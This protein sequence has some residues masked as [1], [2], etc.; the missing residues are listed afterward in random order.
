MYRKNEPCVPADKWVAQDRQ[1]EVKLSK[2]GKAALKRFEDTFQKKFGADSLKRKGSKYEVISTGSLTLD[3]ALGVGGLPEGRIVEVWG[4]Q[5]IGKTLLALLAGVEAQR[6]YPDKQVAFIDMES[7]FD[8]DWAIA[9]GI[10]REQFY[11]YEPETAEDVADA[12]KEFV[13]SGLFS[14]VIVDSVGA[15]VPKKEREKQSD[16]AT[17]GLQAKIVTRMVGINSSECRKT[18]TILYLINQVRA[19]LSYGADTTTGGG[20][21]LKH[22]STIKLKLK[23]TGTQPYVTKVGGEDQRVGHE[24]AALVERNKVALSMK[25]AMISVFV[26]P[27]K[28]YGPI[29]V[30]K[31]DEA[32]TLGI[33][34][35]IIEAKGAWYTLPDG[36]RVK[37]RDAVVEALRQ[38]PEMVTQIRE[39]VL[40]RSADEVVEEEGSESGA[41]PRF[42]KGA[43]DGS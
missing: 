40:A 13:A 23:R 30:D 7:K 3:F 18:G 27:T 10:S 32:A 11:L 9:Q 6:K 35:G 12:V 15:M 21:A 4:Q 43:K 26:H 33:K 41:Q 25:T 20:F 14:M 29:G 17:I 24:I 31:V 22:A 1:G 19:N 16:E 42:R 39:Q 5:D 28:K 8:W 34:L 37:G 2:V 38:A 36:E